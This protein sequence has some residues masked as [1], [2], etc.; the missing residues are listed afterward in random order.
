MSQSQKVLTDK[1]GVRYVIGTE[2]VQGKQV[3]CRMNVVSKCPK[4]EFEW[5]D[6]L[7]PLEVKGLTGG[8][9]CPEC[10]DDQ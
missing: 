8:G 6:V 5:P 4:C 9:G 3:P 7:T 1:K 10:R 2:E